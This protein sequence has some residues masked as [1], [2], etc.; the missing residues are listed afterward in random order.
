MKKAIFLTFTVL[1]VI[2]GLGI[3]YLTNTGLLSFDE[4][5]IRLAVGLEAV[6]AGEQRT[7]EH[8]SGYIDPDEAKFIPRPAISVN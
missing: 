4:A 7:I 8:L 3:L 5:Y 6:L 1:L 2:V